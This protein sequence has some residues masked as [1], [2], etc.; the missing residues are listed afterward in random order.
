MA[1]HFRTST[2]SYSGLNFQPIKAIAL[3]LL[4]LSLAGCNSLPTSLNVPS[5]SASSPDALFRGKYWFRG[6]GDGA[7]NG[8]HPFHE[9]GVVMA[10]G[11]GHWTLHSMSNNEDNAFHSINAIGNYQLAAN[12]VGT[13]SQNSGGCP[14]GL[15]P[16][17]VVPT[18]PADHAAILVSSDGKHSWW[19]AMEGGTTWEVELTRDGEPDIVPLGSLASCTLDRGSV[20]SC[21][22]GWAGVRGW[23]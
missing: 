11:A 14:N 7:G 3:C 2:I 17:D 19:V 22:D 13:E 6:R 5:V 9:F 15:P 8:T 16:A 23:N 1:T 4:A 20:V 21:N 12:G 18:C 10:D